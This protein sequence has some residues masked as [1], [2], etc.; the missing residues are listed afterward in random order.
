MLRVFL[1]AHLEFA[2]QK[3]LRTLF[4]KDVS[5]ASK[6]SGLQLAIVFKWLTQK[7]LGDDSRSLIVL[8][9]SSKHLAFG[10]FNA[11]VMDKAA[12]LRAIFFA[13]G[14]VKDME[15]EFFRKNYFARRKF[16]K[17]EA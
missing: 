9:R 11:L 7:F 16:V 15:A 5:S 17:K 1:E 4:F 13:F 12:I 14:H 3:Y 8:E 2:T 10:F 6:I